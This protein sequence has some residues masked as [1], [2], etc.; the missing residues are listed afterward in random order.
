MMCLFIVSGCITDHYY[1]YYQ[2]HGIAGALKDYTEDKAC[3]GTFPTQVE[4]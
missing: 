3:S 4:S 1:Y 2:V